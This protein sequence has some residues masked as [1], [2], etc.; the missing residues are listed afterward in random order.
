VYPI[1]S[2]DD[3]DEEQKLIRSI[4]L[5]RTFILTLFTDNI[6]RPPEIRMKNKDKLWNA[7]PSL[8]EAKETVSRKDAARLRT[9]ILALTQILNKSSCSVLLF[10]GTIFF[11]TS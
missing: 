9:D 7:S 6:L 2:T 5:S 10:K 1:M 4:N 8:R 11:R 3:T